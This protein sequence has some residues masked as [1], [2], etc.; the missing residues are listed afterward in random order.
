MID[1]LAGVGLMAIA[2]LDS[3]SMTTNVLMNDPAMVDLLLEMPEY[4][5]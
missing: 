1:A 4:F 3:I 2:V 5:G